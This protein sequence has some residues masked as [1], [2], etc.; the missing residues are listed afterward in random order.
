MTT[1]TKL[2]ERE[3]RFLLKER[4]IELP[5]DVLQEL[6]QHQA[7]ATS[8][9]RGGRITEAH[10]MR[11][12]M[13]DLIEEFVKGEMPEDDSWFALFIDMGVPRRLN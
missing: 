6:V 1:S 4:G 8:D 5:E 10:L 13:A 7:D 11:E 9:R 3:L 12:I 2:I